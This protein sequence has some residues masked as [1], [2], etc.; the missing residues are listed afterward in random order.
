MIHCCEGMYTGFHLPQFQ[1]STMCYVVTVYHLVR[2]SGPNNFR[3]GRRT[4]TIHRFNVRHRRRSRPGGNES[5]C[6]YLHNSYHVRGWG[7]SRPGCVVVCFK[8]LLMQLPSSSAGGLK[9]NPYECHCMTLMLHRMYASPILAPLYAAT[10]V[11]VVPG[12]SRACFV[13]A[14]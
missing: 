14:V 12:A 6:P 4:W 2:V 9:G 8:N 13:S 10:P 11:L 3:F 5:Q 1:P 7:R